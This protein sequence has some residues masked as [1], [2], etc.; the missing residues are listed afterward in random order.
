MKG[1]VR[2]EVPVPERSKSNTPALKELR[3]EPASRPL[4]YDRAIEPKDLTKRTLREFSLLR[5]TIF[6]RA[7]NKF[8]K[9]WLD[10]YF[11]AQPWYKP[12]EQLRR[13][14]LTAQDLANVEKI[15]QAEQA[16]SKDRLEESLEKLQSTKS[17]SA[18]QTIELRL[19]SA[20]L[21]KWTDKIKDA[22]R[23]PLEDP[24]LLDKLL[25]L[26]NLEEMS[27]R[28]LRILRNTIYARKGRRFKSHLV[29]SY[30]YQKDWY[31]PVDG[32]KSSMLDSIDRRNVRIVR[33]LEYS[34]GGP[35][36]DDEHPEEDWM[37]VA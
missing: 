16:L 26:K 34:L 10:Q 6:A 29:S 14:L 22:R 19:L 13:D 20:R 31:K 4:Y 24:S 30:F 21:G 8:R 15:V 36:R 25:H 28:D 18:E 35:I 17:L 37:Y 27:R 1:L 33:S 3:A 12:S 9:T 7:G 32:F 11:M 2:V 5:N 23:T